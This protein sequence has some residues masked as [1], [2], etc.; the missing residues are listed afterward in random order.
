AL[1]NR[2][3]A[4]TV[5]GNYD[6]GIEMTTSTGTI[7]AN[8]VSVDNGINSARTAGE[9][10]VDSASVSTTTLND[11]LVF[12][13]VPGEMIDWNGVKY[14]SLAAF[15]S[16]TGQESRGI[17][18]DPRFVSVAGAN[19]HLSAGSPAIDSA[20]SGAP[21][22]PAVDFDNASRFDDPATPNSGI[23]PV[24]YADRG[25]YEYHP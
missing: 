13:R 16:A 17:Q 6:S 8:N 11:D 25:A 21:N 23:G 9:I 18:A 14:A 1:N 5:Y 15:Q 12:L 10:R 4:N 3:I 2:V 19:F 7:V 20:N 22:Q 24:T